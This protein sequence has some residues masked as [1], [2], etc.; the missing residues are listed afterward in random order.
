MGWL[1][2]FAP[3]AEAIGLADKFQDVR[4]VDQAIQQGSGQ[5]L[6]LEDFVPVRKAQ[7]GGEDN[8]NPFI[9]LATQLEEELRFA[10][11][12]RRV[13]HLIEDQQV[14]LRKPR[15]HFKNAQVPLGCL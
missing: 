5:R 1:L 13:A 14:Q 7:I 3:L 2:Q 4:L 8:R 6:I 10:L 12:K 15:R 11:P 9:Q